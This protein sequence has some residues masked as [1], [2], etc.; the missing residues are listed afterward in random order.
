MT[1][2]SLIALLVGT[3]ALA[4]TPVLRKGI[5][6]EM[7]VTKSA[8]P[9]READQAGA[10]IVAVTRNGQAYLEVTPVTPAGLTEQLRAT[11]GAQVYVKADTR[12]PY[13]SVAAVLSALRS[14]G[15]GASNLLSSQREPGGAPMGFNVSL[16]G[17]PD[18]R[19]KAVVLDVTGPMLFGD[20]VSIIDASRAAGAKVFVK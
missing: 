19:E 16:S 7:A 11:R 20:V 17:L 5:S 1:R 13:A 9:M 6:V 4:Q 2:L 3:L 10:L 15:A 14:A 8:T 12:A 18:S